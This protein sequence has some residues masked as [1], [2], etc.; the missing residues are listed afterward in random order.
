MFLFLLETQNVDIMNIAVCVDVALCE[1][2]AL[3][4][5]LVG[6]EPVL[7]SRSLKDNIMYGLQADLCDMDR[8]HN[9]A[10]LSNAH[11]F[12]TAMTDQYDTQAGEK[13]LQ[14]SGINFFYL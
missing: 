3:Q 1:C 8:L 2:C 4:I 6:Q 7:F 11:E 5:A 10:V 9:A 14:L 12:I 13:G